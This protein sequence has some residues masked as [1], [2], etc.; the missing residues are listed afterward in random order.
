MATVDT[1]SSGL[2]LLGGTSS[3]T[4]GFPNNLQLSKDSN[5]V[6]TFGQ[7]TLSA[8]TISNSYTPMPTYT[9]GWS[10]Q[11]ASQQAAPPNS[12]G[13]TGS[14]PTMTTDPTTGQAVWK[15]NSAPT[16]T[17]LANPAPAGGTGYK[18]PSY[19]ELNPA[20]P[21]RFLYINGVLQDRYDRSSPYYL[22]PDAYPNLPNSTTQYS[23]PWQASQPYQPSYAS[24]AGTGQIAPGY[25]PPA[26]SLPPWDPIV[27]AQKS[28]IPQ[29][30]AYGNYLNSLGNG[31]YMPTS[32]GQQQQGQTSSPQDNTYLQQ[33]LAGLFGT[34]QSQYST[35]KTPLG[36]TQYQSSVPQS[37][38]SQG[39]DP[40]MQMILAMLMGQNNHGGAQ[41]SFWNLLSGLQ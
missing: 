5:G 37:S 13:G 23:A 36:Y 38:N 31:N 25:T 8:P 14:A 4:G 34:G 10:T 12:A 11:Q 22:S 35:V 29:S 7:G 30:Q 28:G 15:D 32:G 27:Q 24:P 40:M 26:W 17:Q 41:N 9:G 20:A 3:G 21:T 6:T 1:S 16:T 2:N 19:P 39:L 33:L 18:A